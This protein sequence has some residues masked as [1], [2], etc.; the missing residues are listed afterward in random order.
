MDRFRLR[1]EPDSSHGHLPDIGYMLALDY[2]EQLVLVSSMAMR[3]E[4]ISQGWAVAPLYS[5]LRNILT[6]EPVPA[7]WQQHS[8]TVKA[9]VE[10]CKVAKR[11]SL[12]LSSWLC[13]IKQARHCRVC[14]SKQRTSEKSLCTNGQPQINPEQALKY[15]CTPSRLAGVP[16]LLQKIRLS[17][18]PLVSA[19]MA[20]WHKVHTFLSSLGQPWIG[21]EADMPLETCISLCWSSPNAELALSRTPHGH[22]QKGINIY[23]VFLVLCLCFGGDGALQTS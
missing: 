10:T 23:G 3:E 14:H 17:H 18:H 16:K 8:Q 2:S 9:T 7:N 1:G 6:K 12:Q 5:R 20:I 15:T 21:R 22:G 13:K 11:D 19:V 4:N